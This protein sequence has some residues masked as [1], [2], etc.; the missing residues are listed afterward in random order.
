LNVTSLTGQALQLAHSITGDGDE[1]LFISG[2]SDTRDGWAENVPA[3][4]GYRRVTF[5]NRDVGDS[6]RTPAPY[7]V[8]DMAADALHLLD[9]LEIERAH[10]VGHSMGGAI[11]QEL[12]ILAPAR[13]RSLFLATTFAHSDGYISELVE[14]WVRLRRVLSPG[15]FAHN[16]IFF[17]C[18]ATTI[19]ELGMPAL[20]EAVVP[21]VAA[22]EVEAFVRQARAVL[23]RDRR[24]DLANIHMPTL[25]IHASEDVTVPEY[26]SREL[27]ATIPNARLVTIERSGHSPIFEQAEAFN[28]LVREFIDSVA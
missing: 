28:T 27:A 19:R 17:W 14:G 3:F 2:T 23:H 18:G 12:A 4:E 13:V 16:A 5:D 22:Q 20:L 11:A 9:R 21:V 10:V 15:D 7:T 25:V 1:I 6:P 26:H 24:P 8:A